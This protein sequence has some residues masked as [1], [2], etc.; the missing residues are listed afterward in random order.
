VEVIEIIRTSASPHQNCI[1]IEC[2]QATLDQVV[3][4]MMKNPGYR[5][6]TGLRKKYA[7][8]ICAVLRLIAKALCQLHSTGVVHGNVCMATCGKFEHSWKL[9]DTMGIVPMGMVVDPLRLRTSVP[10]EALH[11]DEGEGDH[12]VFDSDSPPVTFQ[13]IQANP[14]IDIWAFGKLAYETLVGEPLVPFNPSLPAHEDALS[15]LEIVEWDQSCLKRVF[16]G[17]LVSGVTESCAELITSCLFPNPKDRPVSMEAILQDPFWSDM[18]QYRE[19]S[20]PPKQ[21]SA[22]AMEFTA[23]SS[24]SLLT[25]DASSFNTSIELDRSEGFG[26]SS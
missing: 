7:A 4:G 25:E 24:R 12:I 23:E 10:P 1:L 22:H 13:S 16:T 6:D 3:D 5:N 9:L 21:S 17:L 18:R 26:L 20:S 19:R 14:S 11:L 8:K 15:L 2:P